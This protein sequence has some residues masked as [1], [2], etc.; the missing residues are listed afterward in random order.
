MKQS[1]LSS[2]DHRFGLNSL[3][4]YPFV[5]PRKVKAN[6]FFRHVLYLLFAYP[7]CWTEIEH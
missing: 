7:K 2:T 4:A 3:F 5:Y 1:C 6:S